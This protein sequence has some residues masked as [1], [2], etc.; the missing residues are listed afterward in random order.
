MNARA[1]AAQAVKMTA[2]TSDLLRPRPHGVVVLAYHRVG[3]RSNL[4]V[5]LPLDLFT[6]QMEELASSKRVL[7]LDDAVAALG[8]G[9][10][11]HGQVAVTFDDGTADFADIALPVLE[12]FNIPVTLYVATEFIEQG[13]PFPHGGT[14]LSW[15]ALSDAV[16]TGLVTVGSHTHTHMLLDRIP[17][18]EVERE[19]DQSIDL[20]AD[21]LGH[22]ADHF[23]YPKAVGGSP[24]AEAAIRERFKSAAV[25]GT[26]ANRFGRTDVYRLARSPIQVSDGMAWFRRK[27]QGGMGLE[28]DLRR[29][30]NRRRYSGAT[31]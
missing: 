25:A 21:R 29:L 14:P 19:L 23:A 10:G 27:A 3:R 9:D 2:A 4:S 12:R 1:A 15:P 31:T 28:D 5:D 11:Q 13:R 17:R 26:R 20:I 18:E 22:P 16:S 24:H 8:R 6:R 7:A 30:A